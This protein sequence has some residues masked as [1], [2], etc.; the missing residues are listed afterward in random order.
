MLIVLNLQARLLVFCV[1]VVVLVSGGTARAGQENADL[2]IRIITNDWSSQIVLAHIAG[3]VF[4]R[5]D[6]KVEY[7][8][9]TVAEQWGAMA[10]GL[11]HVQVEV[12]EGTMSDM[13][14][15]MVSAGRL[16]DAGSHAA[17]TR[18]EWWYPDYVE[19]LCPG[20][21]DWKAL[22][23]CSALFSEDGS[24]TGRY[25]AGPWEKPEAARVRALGM[26]F[27]VGPVDEADDLWRA[28]KSASKERR[29]VVLFNW[30]PNWIEARYRGKFVEFPKHDPA[31]ETDP[32][33]GVN[34]DF[35][36]D[37]GNP[38]QG[39]LKKAV[40][41]G[42]AERWPCAYKTLQNLSFDNL[43]IAQ[44]AARVD[45]DGLPH[46]SAAKEWLKQNETQWR[47]WID[48]SCAAGL[49]Q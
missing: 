21:P 20:L 44:L 23:A 29:A 35:H 46:E 17:I 49:E 42:M 25:Y 16:I 7:S 19:E 8:S 33:W 31:C 45:V 27:K 18:E 48:A 37:C 43:A 1:F 36:Y 40:W 12:W 22:R 30:T 4:E 15:R 3:G 26:N 24:A 2:P 13:F 28:L 38:A 9:S 41:S 32:A 11:D 39:W 5:L 14:T 47:G 34:P 10:L 6:Y